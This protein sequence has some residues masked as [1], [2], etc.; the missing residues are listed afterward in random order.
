MLSFDMICLPQYQYYCLKASQAMAGKQPLG[1]SLFISCRTVTDFEIGLLLL[2]ADLKVGI[3]WLVLR[4]EF[5]RMGLLLTFKWVGFIIILECN[6]F[7]S[8]EHFLLIGNLC[9][10]V[11]PGVSA[12]LYKLFTGHHNK[13]PIHQI[14]NIQ[15]WN[16]LHEICP[17]QSC[18]VSWTKSKQMSYLWPAVCMGVKDLSICEKQSFENGGENVTLLLFSIC[19]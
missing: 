8:Y 16:H 19:L 11:H 4:S 17:H 18:H 5:E 10:I 2:R 13:D 14:C 1:S 12:W 6:S 3:G 9:W 7:Y 15:A